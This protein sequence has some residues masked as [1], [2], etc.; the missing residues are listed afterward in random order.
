[1]IEMPARAHSENGCQVRPFFFRAINARD[2]RCAPFSNRTI[3]EPQAM[4]VALY[5]RV[6]TT[7]KGQDP[8]NQLAQL[9]QWATSHK[10]IGE[11]IDHESGS[12]ASR[13]A[14]DKLFD[15]AAKRKFDLVLFWALDRFSR[16]GMIP[17]IYHLQRLAA[18]G[19]SFHS[20]TEPF[21]ST[22][23]ELSRNVLLAA[24]SSLA[25]Q[26]R[27]RIS[28]RTKAGLARARSAGKTLGR[29]K[30]AAE[31]EI[32]V[33]ASLARGEGVVKISKALRV[34]VGTILRIKREGHD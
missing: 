7:D 31:K 33:R 29:P 12:K 14:F 17:T 27:Q 18:S 11:Y 25:K 21:L 13:K 24:M 4:R 8:E 23:N 2:L 3:T 19:V 6:S 26:E 22:D 5:A 28:E 34:G 32:A 1:M 30:L 16:E 20:F 15:D 10:V 9:R